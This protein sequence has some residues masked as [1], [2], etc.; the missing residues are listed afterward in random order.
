[1]PGGDDPQPAVDGDGVELAL[2]EP[3]PVGIGERFHDGV[4][5]ATVRGDGTI[6]LILDVLGIVDRFKYVGSEAAA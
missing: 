5:G 6:G 4:G 1:M 3:H 2:R